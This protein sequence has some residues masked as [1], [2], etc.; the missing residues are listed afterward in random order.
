M[1]LASSHRGVIAPYPEGF[2]NDD[3]AATRMVGSATL[4]FLAE[5]F[6][7]VGTIAQAVGIL[8]NEASFP[9]SHT[10]RSRKMTQACRSLCP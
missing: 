5:I 4:L 8:R 3:N 6:R 10:R 1:N 7:M 2:S 9:G